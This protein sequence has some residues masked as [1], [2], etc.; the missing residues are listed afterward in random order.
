MAIKQYS[1]TLEE[2]VVEEA[3]IKYQKNGSK[4]SPLLSQ[5]LKEWVEEQE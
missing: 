5:L 1:V 4:L 2:D 3:K